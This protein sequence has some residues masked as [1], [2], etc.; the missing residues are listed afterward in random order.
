[1]MYQCAFGLIGLPDLLHLKAV[2]VMN[3]LILDPDF[4]VSSWF[5]TTLATLQIV[6][7]ETEKQKSE[8][9]RFWD[10]AGESVL[11]AL[12]AKRGRA[13]AETVQTLRGAQPKEMT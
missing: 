8:R 3:K 4:P 2:A 11:E 6:A 13:L 12:P 5:L 10:A 1:M 7:D 9:N